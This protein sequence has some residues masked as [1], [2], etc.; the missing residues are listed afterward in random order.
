MKWYWSLGDFFLALD[1]DGNGIIACED[2]ELRLASSGMIPAGI[3]IEGAIAMV[4]NISWSTAMLQ[5]RNFAN[6]MA[7]EKTLWKGGHF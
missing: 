7:T 6:I 2:F 3:D 4:M 1:K 5:L